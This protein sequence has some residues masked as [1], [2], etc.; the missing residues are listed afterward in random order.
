[1]I[2]SS[3]VASH[4]VAPHALPAGKD[5][6]KLN[7]SRRE[8]KRAE[9]KAVVKKELD[10]EDEDEGFS[11]IYNVDAFTYGNVSKLFC[12]A[13]AHDL[14]LVSSTNESFSLL[15]KQWTRFA[16]H[17]CQGFNVVT[18]TVYVDEADVTRPLWVYVAHRDI[19]VS[20]T[21]LFRLILSRRTNF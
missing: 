6:G 15:R 1:M 11:A 2:V 5:S 8:K 19:K 13:S 14:V 20:F 10:V 3:T 21:S 12:I 9:T 17:N 16:N 4:K 7:R 18:R